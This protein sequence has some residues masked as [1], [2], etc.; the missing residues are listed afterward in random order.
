MTAAVPRAYIDAVA[1]PQRL[2]SPQHRPLEPPARLHLRAM[3]NLRF[4]RETME[5]ATRFTDVSGSG[6]VA[7][8]LTAVAAAWIAS[9]QGGFDRWIAVWLVDALAAILILAGSSLW[10]ARKTRVDLFTQPIRRF[11]FALFPPLVAGAVLSA[12]L[13]V[14]GDIGVLPGVWL[15]LYGT[16]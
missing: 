1:D 6:A 3:D 2:R 4:I 9:R 5:G 11:A 13:F 15:L 7:A 14:Q 12:V 10:K 16:G 8:G